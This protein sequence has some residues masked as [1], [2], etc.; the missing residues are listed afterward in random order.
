[1][2]V[3]DASSVVGAGGLALVPAGAPH[4]VENAGED[5]LRFI[6]FYAGTDVVTRYLQAV[7]PDGS[8]ERRPLD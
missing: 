5:T 3:G 7:Q 1:V 2:T 6:A 4:Q 8:S